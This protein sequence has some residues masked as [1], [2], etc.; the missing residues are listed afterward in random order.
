MG[1][2]RKPHALID[3]VLGGGPV[4]KCR[5]QISHTGR[6]QP[7]WFSMR[8]PRRRETKILFQHLTA[9]MGELKFKRPSDNTWVYTHRNTE[10]PESNVYRVRKLA[11]LEKHQRTAQSLPREP[12]KTSSCTCHHLVTPGIPE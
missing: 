6:N 2:G 10:S 1:R 8:K 12:H 11:V 3:F 4:L 9:P 7:T 5:V